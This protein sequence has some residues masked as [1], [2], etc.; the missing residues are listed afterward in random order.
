MLYAD[1]TGLPDWIQVAQTFGVPVVILGV[2]IFGLW[3]I[4]AWFAPRFDR[5]IDKH[6]GF[7]DAM[8]AATSDMGGRLHEVNAAINRLAAVQQK[9]SENVA[10]LAD[11]VR[12]IVAL[13][14]KGS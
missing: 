8:E 3:R 5:V 4:A 6:I 10:A 2:F 1:L 7:L 12:K 9:T 11:D 14:N 13:S